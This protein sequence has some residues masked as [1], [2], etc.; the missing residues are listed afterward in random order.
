MLQQLGQ[1]N[2]N[3]KLIFCDV[4]SDLNINLEDLKK[5]NKLVIIPVHLTGRVYKIDK[6]KRLYQKVLILEDAAQYKNKPAGSLVLR[7]LLV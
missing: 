5:I 1:H 4:D 6:I 2:I 3:Y 7:Q